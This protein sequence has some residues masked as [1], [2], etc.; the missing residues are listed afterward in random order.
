[1]YITA[2]TYLTLTRDYT[3]LEALVRTRLSAPLGREAE[4]TRTGSLDAKEDEWCPRSSKG[5]KAEAPAV[6]C[7]PRHPGARVEGTDRGTASLRT[8][9]VVESL[10]HRTIH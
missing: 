7:S 5:R 8:A 4:P 2:S 10:A 3:V 9:F 6:R 1:M